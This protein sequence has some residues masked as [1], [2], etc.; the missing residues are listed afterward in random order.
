[1]GDDPTPGAMNKRCY[2]LR[3]ALE[4]K[5]PPGT[6]CFPFP[7]HIAVA[8]R[9]WCEPC[10]PFLLAYPEETRC[11]R[12]MRLC[13]NAMQDTN[14]RIVGVR[15]SNVCNAPNVEMRLS[16][17]C[18]AS[19]VWH[20]SSVCTVLHAIRVPTFVMRESGF[21]VENTAALARDAIRRSFR[22]AD[23]VMTGLS[24]Q[25]LV[26]TYI[27]GLTIRVRLYESEVESPLDIGP[28]SSWQ[29]HLFSMHDCAISH[30][31][32]ARIC[33]STPVRCA[34]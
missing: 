5:T 27:D 29:L 1:M 7:C 28:R 15:W 32:T 13:H 30:G 19:N 17:L 10:R 33:N 2:P 3:R 14:A 24:P 8:G 34:A 16:N 12:P 25:L 11:S 31:C 4:C 23:H 22:I 9:S 26:D 20:A 18:N 6:H 21:I